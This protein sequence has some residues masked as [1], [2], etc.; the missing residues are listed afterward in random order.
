MRN[1]SRG[2]QIY[3]SKGRWYVYHRK[4]RIRLRAPWGT[5]Q[6]AA[7]CAGA[8]ASVQRYKLARIETGTL[9]HALLEFQSS[10]QYREY[11][12][13]VRSGFRDAIAWL[14]EREAAIM[15]LA[16]T[17]AVARRLRDR[18][19]RARGFRFANLVLACLR[20]LMAWKVET[21][22]LADNPIARV[23]RMPRPKQLV[24]TSERRRVAPV[25][26]KARC[27]TDSTATKISGN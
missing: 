1:P 3:M 25:R 17:P 5:A 21:G 24:P 6:F 2:L 16:L 15:L 19:N 8:E 11:P 23:N 12:L 13:R 18:A 10:D 20:A 14:A 4:S 7:E 26:T 22:A 27:L 9:Q